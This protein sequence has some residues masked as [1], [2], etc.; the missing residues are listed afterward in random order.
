MVRFQDQIAR[1]NAICQWVNCPNRVRLQD[2]TAAIKSLG[3]IIQLGAMQLHISC[4]ESR[5]QQETPKHP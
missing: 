3:P 4:A 2:K 5:N 1:V